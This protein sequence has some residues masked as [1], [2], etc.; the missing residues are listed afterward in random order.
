M[1]QSPRRPGMV[2]A[3]MS[4]FA[5]M[6][7]GGGPADEGGEQSFEDA[8]D[9]GASCEELF[10]IRNEWDPKSPLIEPANETLRSIGCYNS[11][12]ERTDQ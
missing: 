8:V 4:M 3:L 2:L 7:C 10:E 5:L 9:A 1:M 11:S 6:G 12:S